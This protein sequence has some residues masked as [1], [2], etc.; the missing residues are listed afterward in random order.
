MHAI[1]QQE[2]SG[3]D[4]QSHKLH[5]QKRKK[6]QSM[7]TR[8]T[9]S[10]TV[11]TAHATSSIASAVTARH[12]KPESLGPEMALQ[13]P[14]R[15]RS[16]G[17]RRP[18]RTTTASERLVERKS[19]TALHAAERRRPDGHRRAVDRRLLP[20]SWSGRWFLGGGG[21]RGWLL[22]ANIYRC[23]GLDFVTL[24]RRRGRV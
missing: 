3:F 9:D 5:P 23:A 13:R 17:H 7:E 10:S 14:E 4:L 15:R 19:Q 12:W 21:M 18:E 1:I 6:Q 24:I 11:A 8:A 22:V 2:L 16:D 20:I